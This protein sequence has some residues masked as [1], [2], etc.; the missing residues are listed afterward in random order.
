M[1][2]AR[3]SFSVTGWEFFA[4]QLA[5]CT[6]LCRM[7][8]QVAGDLFLGAEDKGSAFRLAPLPP[9]MASAVLALDQPRKARWAWASRARGPWVGSAGVGA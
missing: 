4:H 2:A 6:L 1:H 7:V 8:A 9:D 5:P 3:C